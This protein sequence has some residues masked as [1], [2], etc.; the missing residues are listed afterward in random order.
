V[1]G[2]AGAPAVPQIAELLRSGLPS[3]LTVAALQAI[4]DTESPA[5]T[6]VL[7]WY[8]HHR[9]ATV[10]RSAVGALAKTRG[11]EVTQALRAALSDSD[12]GVRGIA[13]SALGGLRATDAVTDLFLALD[14]DVSEAAASIG[15]LCSPT[16]CE[17]LAARLGRI[18][19]DVVTS[20]LSEVLFRPP[21][22]INSALKV[23]IVE[24]LRDVGT[25]EA[26]K[27]LKEMQERWPAHGS[28]EVKQAIDAGASATSSSPGAASPEGAP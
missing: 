15:Q 21:A 23:K 18:P 22:E 26:H 27:F 25:A 5:A 6:D 3:P 17:K 9:D 20:G 7:T 14:R 24:R 2:R 4:G 19:F 10:R 16:D 12:P 11:P 28:Q 1:S 13:A 8:A